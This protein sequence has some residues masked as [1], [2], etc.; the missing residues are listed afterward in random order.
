MDGV[1]GAFSTIQNHVTPT[2]TE[3]ILA[4]EATGNYADALPLCQSIKGQEV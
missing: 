3:Q 2:P 1:L 4:L